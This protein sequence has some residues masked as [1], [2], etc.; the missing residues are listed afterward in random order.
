MLIQQLWCKGLD[1]DS[2]IPRDIKLQWNSIQQDLQDIHKHKLQRCVTLSDNDKTGEF[3]LVCFCD[4]STKAYAASVYLLQ[5]TQDG[6]KSELIFAKSR[7]A[8]IKSMTIPQLEIM[9]VLIGVRCLKF[10]QEQLQIHMHSKY[11]FTDFSQCA[12]HWLVSQKKLPVFIRNCVKEINQHRDVTFGYVRTDENPANIATRGSSVANL[13]A[14]SL[15][16]KGTKWLE[17]QE[18]HWTPNVDKEIQSDVF[19]TTCVETRLEDTELQSSAQERT[20][21]SPPCDIKCENFSSFSK[22][23][24]VSALVHRF[25]RNLRY[26]LNAKK[27]ALSTSEL[28]RAE[29]LLIYYVQEKHFKDVLVAIHCNKRNDLQRQLNLFIDESGVLRCRGRI[30][31]SDLSEGSRCPILLPK[32]DK[33]TDLVIDNV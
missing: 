14:N 22:L 16:W 11:L 31:N 2:A 9:A 27:C 23:V 33:V 18:S 24:R 17:R 20:F 7:L 19:T 32:F 15:W 26:P 5:S 1:W 4:A 3:K 29:K 21:S 13:C 8:P 28:E 6:H 25:I 10:V 12:L 30:Q